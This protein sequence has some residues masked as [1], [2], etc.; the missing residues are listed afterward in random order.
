M[1]PRDTL[2][3]QVVADYEVSRQSQLL[4]TR[5]DSVEQQTRGF[6]AVSQTTHLLRSK[7]DAPDYRY[8]PDP[9]LAPLVIPQVKPAA[10]VDRTMTDA[11]YALDCSQ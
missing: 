11:T 3:D 2:S 1:T 9:E 5:L 10:A 7:A 6:D 4:E 8:M